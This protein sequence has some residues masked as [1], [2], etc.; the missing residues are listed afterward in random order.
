MG[1]TYHYR[2]T[3]DTGQK[4]TPRHIAQC[5]FVPQSDLDQLWDDGIAKLAFPNL[6]DALPSCMRLPLDQFRLFVSET[7]LLFIT[8]THPWV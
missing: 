4:Q 2:Y 7:F 8:D 6:D 5:I 3:T 1:K